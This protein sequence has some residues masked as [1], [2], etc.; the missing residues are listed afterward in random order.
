MTPRYLT[1]VA[2]EVLI[3][4]RAT[5]ASGA[6]ETAQ[7]IAKEMIEAKGFKAG[8]SKVTDLQRIFPPEDIEAA[9]DCMGAIAP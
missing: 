7:A 8:S 2:I 9:L 6:C 1:R 4:V 3:E 5:S